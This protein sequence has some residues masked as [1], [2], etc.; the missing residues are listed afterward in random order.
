MKQQEQIMS[1]DIKPNFLL[2]FLIPLE[3]QKTFTAGHS[4]FII[5]TIFILASD[6]KLGTTADLTKYIRD[7]PFLTHTKV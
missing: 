7:K 5:F 3:S 2:R 4:Y 6:N 1:S